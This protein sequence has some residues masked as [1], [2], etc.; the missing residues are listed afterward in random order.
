MKAAYYD[1]YGPAEV[2]AIR[3]VETP[4]PGKNDLLIQVVSSAVSTADWRLRASKF[5]PFLWLPGRL[6]FG[7]FKPKRKILGTDFAGRVAAVG[8]SVTNFAPGDAVF[9]FSGHGGHGEYLA[10]PS[11]GPVV[12]KPG[13]LSFDQAAAVPF[14]ALTALVFLRDVIQIRPSQKILILGASGGVGVFAVQLAKIFGAHVT[15]VAST[16]NLDLLRN[17]GA[18]RV[19]DYKVQDFTKGAEAYDVVLD[20]AG[21]SSFSAVKP[22]LTEKGLYVPLEFDHRH[23]WQALITGIRK[24]KR[25]VVNVSGDTQQDL[26]LVAT[27]FERGELRAVIDSSYPLAQIVA[28]HQRVESRHKTGA[29]IVHV[30]APETGPAPA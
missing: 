8:A 5:A 10:L 16:E 1:R 17:L 28:A 18:D 27:Q 13:N 14:G 7:L 26:A 15:G 6:I 2:V 29:V 21:I 24:G 4:T 22:H 30:G 3:D 20:T 12:K 11:D 9:G 25:V 23:I 19:I